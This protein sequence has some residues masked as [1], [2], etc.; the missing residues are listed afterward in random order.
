MYPTTS[1]G[2][3]F[4]YPNP[5]MSGSFYNAN[6]TMRLRSMQVDTVVKRYPNTRIVSH[7]RSVFDVPVI[8]KNNAQLNFRV[9]LGPNFPTQ[10]PV[11]NLMARAEHQFLDHNSLVIHPKL[12]NWSQ[13]MNLADML[14]EIFQEFIKIPPRITSYA[15]PTFDVQ[16]TLNQQSPYPQYM[17]PPPTQTNGYQPPPNPYLTQ[18]PSPVPASSTPSPPPVKVDT[19]IPIPPIPNTFEEVDRLTDDEIKDMLNDANQHKFNEFFDNL[20]YVK[21]LKKIHKDLRDA[22]MAIAMGNINK[23]EQVAKKKQPLIVKQQTLQT[24]QDEYNKKAV[25]QNEIATRYSPQN[26]LSMLNRKIDEVD[27]ESEDIG[28]RFLDQK[29]DVKTFMDEFVAKKSLYYLRREKKDR[30]KETYCK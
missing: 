24:V 20:T 8:L 2:R 15:P 14:S 29:G 27:K 5:N 25:V 9:T 26:L 18:T 16:Q 12:R 19:R 10:A 21:N 30:F 6:D 3:G 11:V 23:E 7:D 13:Q 4:G 22:N 28:E 17:P 1:V